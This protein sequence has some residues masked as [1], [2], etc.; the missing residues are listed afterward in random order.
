AG[1]A[2]R[3]WC[4]RERSRSRRR[5]ARSSGSVRMRSMGAIAEQAA[6]QADALRARGFEVMRVVRPSGLLRRLLAT[7]RHFLGLLYGGLGAY[8]RA[9]REDGTGRGLKFLLLRGLAAL[10]TPLVDR[11]LRDEPFPVQLRRRLERLGPTYIKLGQILSLRE[12]LLPKPITS[13]LK[14]LL[15]RLPVVP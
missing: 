11:R 10:T 14:H 13:E 2:W 8:V 5:S 9:R 12:D 1:R 3:A 15:N 7:W 6:G 4:W